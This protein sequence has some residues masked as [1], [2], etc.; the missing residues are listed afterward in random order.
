MISLMKILFISST[1]L[2]DAIITTGILE[3]LR[4]KY[5]NAQFT[6]AAGRV[7]LP[8]FKGM[9]Q[10]ERLIA[11]DK[12]P[13]SLHWLK[14][15]KACVLTPWDIIVDVRG[16]GLSYALFAKKRFIWKKTNDRILR[17]HQLAKWMGLQST[18]PSKIHLND[19]HKKDAEQWSRGHSIICLSPTANWDKKSWPLPSFVALSQK[20]MDLY[21]EAKIAILGAS[22]QRQD[23][24]LLFDSLPQDKLLD[25]VGKVDLPTLAAI[26]ERS[27]LFVGND[28]GLMHLAAAMGTPTLGLFGPSDDALY[29]P[30]G[31]NAH[32]IRTPLSFEDAFDQAKQGINPMETLSVEAVIEKIQA[33][34]L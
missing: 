21:P 1:Y 26:L 20:V 12:E 8:L 9:P 2:G 29:G 14:L 32:L 22:S 18:P 27:L 28:S 34:V 33:M 15:W 10:L 5:P 6:I 16:T 3:D 30:W 11:I 23:L 31:P 7:P 13:Y 17:V 25:W 4:K 24:D 19:Q